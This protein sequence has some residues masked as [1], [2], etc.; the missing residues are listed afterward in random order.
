MAFPTRLSFVTYNLWNIQRWPLRQAALQG[1]FQRFRPDIF[2]LQEVRPE[3]QDALEAI[4]PNYKR[5]DDPFPGWERENTIFWNGNLLEEVEHGAEDIG[6]SSDK[7]RRMFWAR[8]KVKDSGQTLFVSTA[9]YTYQEHPDEL[10]TGQSPRLV[11]AQKTVE[12]LKQ[13]VHQNEAGFFMGDLNDPVIP[14]LVL[15]QA[16]Y[17]SSFA[18]LELLPPPTWPAFPTARTST[19]Q[20]ISNQAIDWIVANEHARPIISSVPQYFLEDVTPSDHWPVLAV[21]ELI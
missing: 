7:Y 12:V 2:C 4:L 21:Y 3:T 13:L 10:R 9:H 11:Q 18:A 15:A 1:F 17:K 6:I 5:V 19:W 14:T 20:A 8:L 16:G